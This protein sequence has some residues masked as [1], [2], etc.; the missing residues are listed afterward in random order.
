MMKGEEESR[1][2]EILGEME[3][4]FELGCV[5]VCVCVGQC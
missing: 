1:R 3:D 5:C 2:E 4:C